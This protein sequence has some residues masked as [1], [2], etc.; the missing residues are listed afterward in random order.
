[1]NSKNYRGRPHETDLSGLSFDYDGFGRPVVN[2]KNRHTRRIP[3]IICVGVLC[4]VLIS[5]LLIRQFLHGSEKGCKPNSGIAYESSENLNDSFSHVLSVDPYYY[6][7]ILS[8]DELEIYELI[9]EG[10]LSLDS[11]ITLPENI[12]DKLSMLCHMVLN[13]HPEIFW[14]NGAYQY[15]EYDDKTEVEIHYLYS[16]NEI[17]SRK[18]EIEV[19]AND[20]KQ[21][22]SDADTEY[23]IVKKAYLYL[24]DTVEYVSDSSDNQNIYSSLVNKKTVCAGYAKATQYL[25]QQNG[26]QALYVS[27]IADGLGGWDN[28]AW[29]IVC[30]NGQYYQVDTTFGDGYKSPD[31]QT[32]EVGIYN[33]AYLCIDDDTMYRN[34]QVSD[35]LTVPQCES[36]DL[37]Y[38]VQNG[39]YSNVFDNQVMDSMRNSVFSGDTSWEYQFSNFEAYSL[40]LERIKNGAYSS[41]VSEYL[42]RSCQI[43]YSYND[44]MYYVFCWY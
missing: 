29:N 6:H 35:E 17:R 18:K 32:E 12:A 30:C 44:T 21:M 39:L 23:D 14:T 20:F 11:I 3:I 8:D 26:V 33:Y 28:H 36:L 34:H 37:S 43:H 15:T 10:V 42:G 41:I 2:H 25:L 4:I 16:K 38:Y 5:V 1:M 31:N 7:S 40:C 24:I 22:L 19:A 27:G 9:L 13:D